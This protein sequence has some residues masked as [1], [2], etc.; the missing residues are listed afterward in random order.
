MKKNRRIGLSRFTVPHATYAW[1]VKAFALF[2]LV[3]GMALGGAIGLH[4]IQ[5]IKAIGLD[6]LAINPEALETHALKM[7]IYS[8][9]LSGIAF[10]CFTLVVGAFLFHRI[11]GP[12]YRLKGHMLAL[13]NDQQ[14]HSLKLRETDQLQDIAEVYNSLLVKYQII[15][16]E[17]PQNS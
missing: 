5:M 15:K 10:S 9:T 4:Q 1:H 8:V 7:M 11:C 6:E 14:V 2:A 13:L 17:P 3:A 16:E 12:I